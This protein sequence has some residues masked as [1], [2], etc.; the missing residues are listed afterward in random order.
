MNR[1]KTIFYNLDGSIKS[2]AYYFNGRFD[3]G[4]IEGTKSHCSQDFGEQDI[5]RLETYWRQ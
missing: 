2:T 5:E 3:H 1:S 4:F